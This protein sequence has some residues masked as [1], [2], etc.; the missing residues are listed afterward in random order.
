MDPIFAIGPLSHYLAKLLRIFGHYT[1]TKG[2]ATEAFID[3]L[4]NT[5]GRILPSLTSVKC[6]GM[7]LRLQKNRNVYGDMGIP[8]I[9]YNNA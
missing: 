1:Q 3:F 7:P 2:L 5:P 8:K 4:E 9:M 6:R